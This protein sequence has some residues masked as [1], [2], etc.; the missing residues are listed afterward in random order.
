MG[1]EGRVEEGNRKG[2][3]KRGGEKTLRRENTEEGKLG[4]RRTL[5]GRR[6]EDNA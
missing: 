4:G 2:G 6:G 1:K 3:W 5:G